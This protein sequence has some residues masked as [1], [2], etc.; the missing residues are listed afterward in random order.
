MTNKFDE[1]APEVWEKLDDVAKA[2]QTRSFAPLIFSV[3]TTKDSEGKVNHRATF[4][5]GSEIIT[6][7]TWL[8]MPDLAAMGWIRL[9]R[10]NKV[11]ERHFIP[12][13]GNDKPDRPD[14]FTDRKKWELWPGTTR[15][16]DPW[17]FSQ[18]MPFKNLETGKVIIF[19]GWKIGE[20]V[21]MGELLADFKAKRR[22]Q[23]VKLTSIK[24][25]GEEGLDPL[26]EII[27]RSEDDSD[28]PGL[29]LAV[30]NVVLTREPAKSN[31]SGVKEKGSDVADDDM[32]DDIPF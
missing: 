1:L 28:V 15:E 19:G 32:D 9:S 10:E 4:K 21:A 24:R 20:S 27:S 2:A 3:E 13:L 30:D 29:M 12:T 5:A 31:G 17:V 8:A 11:L 25:D 14:S 18:S 7:E 26:F 6:N 22:R 16:K 23:I